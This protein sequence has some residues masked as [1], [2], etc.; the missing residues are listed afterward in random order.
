MLNNEMLEITALADQLKIHYHLNDN[1]HQ[2]D[3]YVRNKCEQEL[4]GIIKEISYRLDIYTKVDAEAKQE[5]G[6]TDIYNFCVSAEGVA[7][8]QWATLL[9]LIIQQFLPKKT[10]KD[11]IEQ[12]L[13]IELLR[14]NIENAKKEA[15]ENK[16]TK[17]IK[18]EE[19]INFLANKDM[20]LKKKKSNFFKNLE[21]VPKV[22]KLEVIVL[23]KN[24]PNNSKSII[25]PRKDFSDYI[26]VTDEIESVIDEEANIEIVAPVLVSQGKYSWRGVYDKTPGIIEF[27][28]SDKDFKKS[29]VEDG[30][31]FQNGTVIKC[32]LETKKKLN[33]GGDIVNSGYKVV[34]VFDQYIGDK[35][36]E[37]EKGKH[38]RIV[39]AAEKAQLKLFSDENKSN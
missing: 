35:H 38:R 4:L 6:L 7:L 37:T 30:L 12:D 19:N 27:S 28:M 11:K 13:N 34:N 18:L 39:K 9:L 32:E 2:L 29:I 23:D 5:G 10:T 8:A 22:E 26:L 15:Q 24:N 16:I 17:E 31:S 14:L 21:S 1:S 20:K 3:A 25:I 36:F 33:D